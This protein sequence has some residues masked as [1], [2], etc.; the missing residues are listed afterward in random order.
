MARF[1][2]DQIST[3]VADLKA[4]EPMI[5]RAASLAIN[6][7]AT[8][9]KNLSV[10]FITNEVNLEPNYVKQN[11]KQVQRA[12]PDNL[13]AII[14]ANT[15]ETLLTRYPNQ[16]TK[17]GVKVAVNR[18]SGFQNIKGAFRVNGLRG[19]Q[20][21]GIAVRNTDALRIF[22]ANLAPATP[23]KRKKVLRAAQRAATKP[24]SITVLHSRSINQLFTSVREDVQPR[25]F[26]F[27]A[28]EFLSDLQRLQS[29][30]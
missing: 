22:K 11:I 18:S 26:R 12:S 7:A 16:V 10:E 1:T 15:R 5:N 29:K 20:A 13:V 19:S 2:V 17:D 21:S 9:S 6:K 3:L 4:T 23:G 28:E 30:G 25:T 8:F 27:M 24:R 14:R